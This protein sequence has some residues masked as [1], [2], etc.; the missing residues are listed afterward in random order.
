MTLPNIHTGRYLLCRTISEP[1]IHIATSVLIE[2]VNE[3]VEELALYNFQIDL[4]EASP[5]WL[6]VGTI[7]LIKEPYLKYESDGKNVLIRVDSPSDVVF[8]EEDDEEML[9]EANALKWYKKNNM[10]FEEL[11]AQG[12]ELYKK[13]RYEGM[14]L[15]SRGYMGLSGILGNGEKCLKMVYEYTY[16]GLFPGYTILDSIYVTRFQC[17]IH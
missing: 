9:N 10:T 16:I 5:S 12:N 6:S 15:Y 1:Y 13:Q 11:K 3:D 2:D 17:F 7:L 8:I 14:S 4:E